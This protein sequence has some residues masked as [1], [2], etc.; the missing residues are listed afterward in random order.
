MDKDDK[1][2]RLLTSEIIEKLGE[3][4]INVNNK[5][6]ISMDIFINLMREA[7]MKDIML[8]TILSKEG[9]K[10]LSDDDILFYIS[11]QYD[12][13]DIR[14]LDGSYTLVSV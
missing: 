14:Y 8:G 3:E 1:F 9:K 13:T 11:T 12:K 4:T 2:I 10:N 6:Y 5:E 7:M